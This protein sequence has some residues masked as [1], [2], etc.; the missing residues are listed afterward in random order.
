LVSGVSVF[1]SLLWNFTSCQDVSPRSIAAFDEEVC[2][3]TLQANN[4]KNT[5]NDSKLTATLFM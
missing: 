2:S 3:R 4:S 1:S 5:G